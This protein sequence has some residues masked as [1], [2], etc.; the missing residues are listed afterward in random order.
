MAKIE[1]GEGEVEA[2]GLCH[3][4]NMMKMASSPCCDCAS[5]S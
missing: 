1:R 5:S 2:G 4:K 3:L